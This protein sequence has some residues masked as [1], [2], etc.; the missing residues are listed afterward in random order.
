MSAATLHAEIVAAMV[1]AGFTSSPT[2]LA[3]QRMATT[4]AYGSGPSGS[5][6]VGWGSRPLEGY[7]GN[8]QAQSRPVV[9]VSVLYDLGTDPNAGQAAALTAGDTVA[10]V[11]ANLT[12]GGG[13]TVTN[14]EHINFDDDRWQEV[15]VTAEGLHVVDLSSS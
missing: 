2:T 7:T 14:I 5:F 11:L 4:E 13:W 10:A 15:Q 9:T 12:A 3:A 6:V 1:A 8:R